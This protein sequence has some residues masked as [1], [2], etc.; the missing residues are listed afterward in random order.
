MR[1][2][3]N[4]AKRKCNISDESFEEIVKNSFCALSSDDRDFILTSYN[5]G[6][7]NYVVEYVY[8][9]ATKLLM[10][11]VFS[12]GEEMVVS[13]THY[14]D[15]TFVSKFFDIF[16]LRLSNEF[17]LISKK[18]KLSIIKII[19]VLQ[20]RQDN[21]NDKHEIDK[22]MAKYII[23]T[24]YDAILLKDFTP[25]TTSI[26]ETITAL[27][28]EEIKPYEDTYT[29]I[30]S[31]SVEQKNLLVRI[32]FSLLSSNSLDP[33]AQKILSQNVKNVFPFIWDCVSLNDKKFFT[34][35]LRTNTDNKLLVKA[36]EDM[37][38]QIRLTDLP[39]D[40]SEVSK[41]FKDCQDV[42]SFHYGI[43]SHKEEVAPLMR[44]QDNPIRSNIMLRSII[45]PALVC[46]LG[47]NYGYLSESR[48]ISEKI[49]GSIS[50]DKWLYYFK[51][52]FEK[53]D[54]TLI[55]L[56]QVDNCIKDFCNII[57]KSGIVPDDI[58]SENVKD[59]IIASKKQD[60]DLVK[61]L[62]SKIYFKL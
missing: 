43:S 32:M 37:T 17:G 12:V 44:I 48:S 51:N 56:F 33:K 47:G 10:E 38:G 59:L 22:E 41:L 9:K 55:N 35:I 45:T 3:W 57:K 20:R 8:G 6:M 29:E 16:V 36:F 11:A 40:L 54:F 34:Y 2:I 14:L 1:I 49:L 23:T 18:E 42:L 61:L 58:P 50:S 30:M 53:D 62:A 19:E 27:T 15:K 21:A 52:F 31:S 24:L 26:L 60:V 5:N 28:S 25:F 46:Y 4:D 13:L 39:S 7:Y